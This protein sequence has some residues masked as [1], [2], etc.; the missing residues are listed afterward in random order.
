[1]RLKGL[2]SPRTFESP[3][4]D[5]VTHDSLL[6]KCRRLIYGSDSSIGT[7][8][9]K[10]KAL[11]F[12]KDIMTKAGEMLLLCNRQRLSKSKRRMHL[13]MRILKIARCGTNG[14][15]GPWTNSKP[16]K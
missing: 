7:G 1:M 3:D 16:K 4:Y 15:V 8:K 10:K 9:N 14:L 13:T 5:H 12:D 6:E 11:R 2:V